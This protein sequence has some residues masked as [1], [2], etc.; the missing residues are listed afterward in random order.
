VR[1]WII[2]APGSGKSVI[3]SRLAEHLCTTH[4]ELDSFYWA[5][6]WRINQ[7]DEFKA[8]VS[9]AVAPNSWVID[10]NYVAAEPIL[11]A[12]AAI[13]LW[14]DLPFWI[15][16]PRV[17]YRTWKRITT[18]EE[19]WGGNRESWRNTLHKDGMPCY[20]LIKHRRN[21]KRLRKYWDNFSG[22]K[23]RLTRFRHVLEDAIQACNELQ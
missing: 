20:A 16:Y 21:Q 19:L 22:P 13:L 9:E 2:G 17:L 11:S 12:R 10:G 3:G 23:K 14:I 8:L 18:R 6:G 7:H 4:H 1:V 15:T 5:I